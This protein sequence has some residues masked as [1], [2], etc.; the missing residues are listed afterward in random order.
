MRLRNV[1][2]KKEI[3]DNSNYLVKHPE[4]Y[5]G[6]WNKL[7][8]NSNPIYIEIGM[9]KGKFIIDNALKYPDINFIGIEKYDSVIA[10]GL[11]KIPDGLNNLLMV[12]WD[13]LNINDIF[14][15]EID[16]IYLNFSDPWPKTRHH[17]R[18]LSSRLFLEKYEYI[19]K[20]NK[21]IE[22]R[23]DNRDLFQYSLVSFSEAGYVLEKV[24]L[25]LHTDDMPEITTEYEDKFSND[26]MPIYYVMCNKDVNK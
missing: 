16:R 26:G 19:F 22:M 21:I 14:S 8:N 6:K 18:R 11:Q 25:D 9:G 17:L 5:K 20:S 4:E 1:K 23:T 13:A 24:S 15:K 7:F 3:M 12:R 2:N 10:K